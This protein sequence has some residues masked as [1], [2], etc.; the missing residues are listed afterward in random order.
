LSEGRPA[1]EGI[2]GKPCGVCDVAGAGPMTRFVR[3]SRLNERGTTLGA[4]PRLIVTE[5]DR[6]FPVRI[7]LAIP[8]GL[9]G[10]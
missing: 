1:A 7:R 5:A 8:T 4:R 2:G 10:E 6:R 3:A 9:L